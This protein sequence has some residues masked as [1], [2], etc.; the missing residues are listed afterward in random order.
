MIAGVGDLDAARSAVEPLSR[1]DY[2]Y[3]PHRPE[4]LL[5][6]KPHGGSWR[7]QTH[8]LHLTEPG[9]ALWRERLAF[10]DA[11]RA[12]ASL[13]SEYAEWKRAHS[14]GGDDD[15]YSASKTPFV[16]RVLASQGIALAPD[17]Q[18]LVPRGAGA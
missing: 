4:A 14:A 12:D 3:R 9:S 8:H 15:P 5:F 10:R 7:G 13:V 16:T 17:A 1:L 6:D 18:R 11:L 2:H